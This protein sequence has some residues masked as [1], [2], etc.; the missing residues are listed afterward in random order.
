MTDV[1]G[2]DVVVHV[3]HLPFCAE[4][5]IPRYKNKV[6]QTFF[7]GAPRK[8]EWRV[9]KENRGHFAREPAP[10]IKHSLKEAPRKGECGHPNP[11]GVYDEVHQDFEH[12]PNIKRKKHP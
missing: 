3:I 9:F 8:G 10:N 11:V 6:K 5:T 4:F 7:R 2:T 1:P 12:S